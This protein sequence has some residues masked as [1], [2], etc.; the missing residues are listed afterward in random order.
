[1]VNVSLSLS[2][3][4]AQGASVIPCQSGDF[5]ALVLD[6]IRVFLPGYG[7]E[8]SRYARAVAKSLVEA[9]ETMDRRLEEATRV[10]A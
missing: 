10:K 6:D 1:M 3:T 4:S 9:A 8:S 5:I 2:E 7:S